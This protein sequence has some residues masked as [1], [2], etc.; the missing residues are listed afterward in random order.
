[1]ILPYGVTYRQLHY[2][3]SKGYIFPPHD[4][5]V[6]PGSGHPR[7]WT[8]KYLRKLEAIAQL[9]RLGFEI[10]TASHIAETVSNYNQGYTDE[11]YVKLELPNFEGYCGVEVVIHPSEFFQKDDAEDDRD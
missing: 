4:D 6:N 11:I 3:A 8:D 5:S 1:M 10:E 9:R 7:G 2:W